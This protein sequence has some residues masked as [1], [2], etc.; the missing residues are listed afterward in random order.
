MSVGAVRSS[1]IPSKEQFGFK[2][3]KRLHQHAHSHLLHHMEHFEANWHTVKLLGMHHPPGNALT[4][5]LE[6]QRHRNHTNRGSSFFQEQEMNWYF[7]AKYHFLLKLSSAL[8]VSFI[9]NP[10][11]VLN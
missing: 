9:K 6:T 10:I 8:D 2:K 4:K 3:N 1:Q 11:S 7:G 5:M